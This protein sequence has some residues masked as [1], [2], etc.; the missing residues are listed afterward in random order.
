MAVEPQLDSTKPLTLQTS[1]KRAESPLRRRKAPPPQTSR[2]GNP[3]LNRT[4]VVPHLPLTAPVTRLPGSQTRA[5]SLLALFAT[6][7]LADAIQTMLGIQRFGPAVEA[8]PI[9][10][11]YVMFGGAT[12]ALIGAKLFAVSCGAILYCFERYIP[13]TLLT[14][15]VVFSAILPWALLLAN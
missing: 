9:V 12:A 14:L 6:T 10:S 8:N 15:V 7:H 11:F 4:E 3:L 13:L 5:V 2:I 1:P